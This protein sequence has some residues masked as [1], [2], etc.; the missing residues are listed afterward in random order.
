MMKDFIRNRLK[1]AKV[2]FKYKKYNISLYD[3]ISKRDTVP[4]DK[5]RFKVHLT[6][7][8]SASSANF[9]FALFL[10]LYYSGLL[11][12]FKL[13]VDGVFIVFMLVSLFLILI[14]N[15][16]KQVSSFN[17]YFRKCGNSNPP[18]VDK[19]RDK[20]GI[21][22]LVKP[23]SDK[24]L[25]Y[26]AKGK[27]YQLE[28]I[29]IVDWLNYRDNISLKK[30]I[31][32]CAIM[33]LINRRSMLDKVL[34]SMWFSSTRAF[35]FLLIIVPAVSTI[36]WV[37]PDCH[38]FETSLFYA[39]SCNQ[40]LV[41]FYVAGL[42]WLV[43]ALYTYFSDFKQS[44]YWLKVTPA[45]NISAQLPIFYFDN[46]ENRWKTY[47]FKVG[48]EDSFKF[49]LENNVVISIVISLAFTIYITT[50]TSLLK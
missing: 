12:F 9:F 22:I 1:I 5:Y 43:Y 21:R 10:I 36:L 34:F 28:S 40:Y 16:L 47:D 20:E 11:L 49:G 24:F 38:S 29:N 37:N 44:Y 35:S 41:Y 17:L 8:F 33:L 45:N 15:R 19:Q 32:K 18:E 42:V 48:P 26:A 2:Y 3:L 23:T 27:T 14:N 39:H 4:A 13:E 50:I 46:K 6:K 7:I 25:P 30:E 31:I